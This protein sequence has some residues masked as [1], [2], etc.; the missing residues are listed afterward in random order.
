M[1][2]E[3]RK[4]HEDSKKF[5]RELEYIKKNQTE[6]RNTIT[7]LKNTREGNSSRSDDTEKWISKLKLPWNSLMLNRKKRMKRNEDRLRDSWNNIKDTNVHFIGV[8]EGD[9]GEEGGREHI[10]RHN[11]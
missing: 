1:L 8:P 2:K 10:R 3:L 4:M 6:L 9:E 5:N 7:K 11:S